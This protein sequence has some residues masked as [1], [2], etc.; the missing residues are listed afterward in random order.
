M[1]KEHKDLSSISGLPDELGIDA[2][3]SKVGQTLTIRKDTRRYGKS[4]TIV[5]GFQMDR[6]EIK[7][8]ASELK[9]RLACGGT[10]EGNE[11]ELQGD[12]VQRARDI[13]SEFGYQ[14]A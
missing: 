1:E 8:L 2:D 10:V 13:L 3:L 4:M 7:E 5:S 9:H 12:H 11:I 6:A 14:V